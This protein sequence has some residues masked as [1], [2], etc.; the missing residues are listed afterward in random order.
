MSPEAPKLW[1]RSRTTGDRGYLYEDGERMRIRL[2]RPS[3]DVSRLFIPGEWIEEA[4]QRKFTPMQVAQIAFAADRQL[5]TFLGLH[6][7]TKR[8]WH[9]LREEARIEFMK[10]GPKAPEIRTVLFES[11]MGELRMYC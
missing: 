7:E 3:E 11:I 4:E 9:T 8:E 5:C 6:T 1:Y 10:H 2:D